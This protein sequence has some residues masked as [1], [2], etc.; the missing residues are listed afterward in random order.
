MP[1]SI[2]FFH[3]HPDDEALLTAGTMARASAEGQRVVLVTATDGA[4]GLASADMSCG[5]LG[6]RRLGELARSARILGVSRTDLL[7][8]QDS[9]LDGHSPSGQGRAFCDVPS[10]EVAGRLRLILEE[11]NASVLV[12]YDEQGG[13]GHPDH[14]HVYR[15]G[16]AAAADSGVQR[17]FAATAPREPFAWAVRAAGAVATFPADFDPDQFEYA[18]TP[19]RLITHRVDVRDFCDFKRA[20]MR[21]HTSQTTGASVRTLSAL[22]KLPRPVFRSILGTEYYRRLR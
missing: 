15:C 16:L 18:F 22:L 1:A 7:G 2:V 10:D 11:E 3:A 19:N 4:A 13:Y 8:Y 9:G 12:V 20:S 6:R 5:G 14:K 17:V 21:A